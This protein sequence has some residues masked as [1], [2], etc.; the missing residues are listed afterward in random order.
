M[1]K[2]R[3]WL[4]NTPIN[5]KFIPLQWFIIT[6]VVLLSLF[7]IV[8]VTLVNSFSEDVI[9]VNVEH[10][11]ELYEIIRNMYIC[12][13][14]GRDILLQ[15]DEAVRD[16]LYEQY[17]IAFDD[18]DY[19]MDNF[20]NVLSGEKLE[21]FNRIIAEK[22]IY[23]ESMILSADI[24]IGGGS[25]DEALYALQVVTPIANDFFGSI[26]E[27]LES[28][29][30]LMDKVLLRNDRLVL[31]VLI[32]GFAFN[33]LAILGVL[34]FVKFFSK[35]MSNSLVVLEQSV[36]KIANTGN[37]K[38]E[39]PKELYTSDEVGRIATVV[40]DMKS[41]LLK[42][43]FNDNLTGGYNAKAYHE[44]INDI[45]LEEESKKSFWCVISD[46]NNLKII[47][48][49]L[50]HLEG[51]NALRKVYSVLNDGLSQYGKT[52]RI[53][54]DE[55]VSLVFDCTKQELEQ[56]IK[57]I[58]EKI[59]KANFEKEHQF[60]LAFGY[61]QFTGYTKDEFNEFFKEVDKQMY[62]NKSELKQARIDA[63]IS[64]MTMQFDK[65]K[66]SNKEN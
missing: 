35:N 21:E 54:G 22:N 55:F 53:G 37:M 1:Q 32:T 44:E 7:S 20:A 17:I 28:E 60:S 43:S 51:D 65:A 30:E 27:F 36:S 45:F 8:S 33:V 61:D 10:K 12:R 50:G 63:R 46:M 64:Q 31:A 3:N 39:I 13:V 59:E 34:A 42:Y 2:F 66:D 40:N 16:Q 24:W 6:I 52:F 26:D 4:S 11:E 56:N 41:M 49:Y 23:K 18:L 57:K 29:Q 47:N 19:K 9:D 48:D 5:K 15:Q 38:I 14:L 25:Y 58:T 62:Y